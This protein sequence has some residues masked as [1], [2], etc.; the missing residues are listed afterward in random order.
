[1]NT[2]AVP[3]LCMMRES[4]ECSPDGKSIRRGLLWR[5][6]SDVILSS[7]PDHKSAKHQLLRRASSSVALASL[8]KK[9]R[10]IL[11]RPNNK[12]R[13]T[14]FNVRFDTVTIREYPIMPGDNPGCLSGPP[15][16]IDWEHQGEFK[17]AIDIYEKERPQR[18]TAGEICMPAGVRLMM[19]KDNGYTTKQILTYQKEATVIRNTRKRCNE[20][21][22]MAN[23]TEMTEKFKRGLSNA[24]IGRG[25]KQKER[26][27]IQE[28]LK[29]DATE[30]R[31]SS[32]AFVKYVPGERSGSTL[33]DSVDENF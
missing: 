27:F 22:H 31:S 8:E 30:K 11:S 23:M 12:G 16:T 3:Q 13:K 17:A 4:S 19:L 20:M 5:T 10:G 21:S 25:K 6:L 32:I 7:S 18:R 26:K 2:K 1:M 28:A 24:T 29:F 15:I 9:P 14:E 33:D